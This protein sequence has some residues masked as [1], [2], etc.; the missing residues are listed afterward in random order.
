MAEDLLVYEV[1]PRDG[2]QNEATLVPAAEKIAFLRGLRDVG[3]K[4]IEAT[5]F[6]SPKAIPQMADA[7]EIFA[8]IGRDVA[9]GK[10]AAGTRHAA[11]VINEK[12]YDR[13][14]E[15]GANAVAIV[16]V[17]SETLSNRNSRMTVDEGIA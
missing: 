5:S 6:V 8:A 11:L 17:V 4:A 3:L 16:V 7:P 15:A 1:G 9:A 2:L 12:G 14:R 13:A 10:V